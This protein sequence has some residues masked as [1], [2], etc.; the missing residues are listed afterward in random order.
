VRTKVEDVANGMTGCVEDARVPL[1]DIDRNA[2]YGGRDNA[3]IVN[4][5]D[6]QFMLV[7]GEPCKRWGCEVKISIQRWTRNEREQVAH[8]DRQR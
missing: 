4:F 3:C 2:V 1:S 6:M 5:D 8:D 7:N